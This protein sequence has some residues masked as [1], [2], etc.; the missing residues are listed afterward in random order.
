[1]CMRG[2]RR[3]KREAFAHLLLMDPKDLWKNCLLLPI[4]KTSFVVFPLLSCRKIHKKKL[5]LLDITVL[6]S[7]ETK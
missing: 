3:A 6:G 2:E 4:F 1:M 7:D 5:C